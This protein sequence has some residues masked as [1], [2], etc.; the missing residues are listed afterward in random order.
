MLS[1]MPTMNR[2]PRG[3]TFHPAFLRDL[4]GAPFAFVRPISSR[5]DRSSGFVLPGPVLDELRAWPAWSRLVLWYLNLLA[6]FVRPHTTAFACFCD[7]QWQE[8]GR[9]DELFN[10]RDICSIPVAPTNGKSPPLVDCLRCNNIGDPAFGAVSAT[11]RR[12]G[13][14]PVSISRMPL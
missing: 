9:R 14:M 1:P 7:V 10:P 11:R 4:R 2:A 5:T 13:G 12:G 6:A 8:S 3:S